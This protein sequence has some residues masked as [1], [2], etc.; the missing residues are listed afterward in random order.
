[1][2]PRLCACTPPFVRQ[3]RNKRTCVIQRLLCCV[4]IIAQTDIYPIC[5]RR[6]QKVHKISTVHAIYA[7]NKHKFRYFELIKSLQRQGKRNGNSGFT[8]LD[9]P[10]YN[11]YFF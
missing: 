10:S 3:S 4:I 5:N 2:T 1:M 8:K 7:Q 11:Y 6:K 9:Q